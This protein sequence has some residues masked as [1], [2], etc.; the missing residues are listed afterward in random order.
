MNLEEKNQKKRE[1]QGNY[2]KIINKNRKASNINRREIFI[3]S[4]IMFLF[5]LIYI[6][7]GPGFWKNCKQL[8]QIYTF[9]M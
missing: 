1:I 7:A 9:F 3:V 5:V 6:M 4:L 2:R 8:S